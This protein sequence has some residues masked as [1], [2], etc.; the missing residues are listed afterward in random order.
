[1]NDTP[2]KYQHQDDLD[3]QQPSQQISQAD[4]VKG[5]IENLH[6]ILLPFIELIY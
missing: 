6:C 5:S 1:M 4:E 2:E 3:S